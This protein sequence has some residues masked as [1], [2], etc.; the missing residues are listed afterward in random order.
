[1]LNKIPLE[2]RLALDKILHLTPL[3]IQLLVE[4]STATSA[5]IQT[6]SFPTAVSIVEPTTQPETVPTMVGPGS[7]LKSQP[8]TPIRLFVLEHELSNHPDKTFVM[9]LIHDLQ[10]YDWLQWTTIC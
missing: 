8:G 5:A 1:M 2:C 4:T 6:A 3:E 10:L 9:Q 7:L